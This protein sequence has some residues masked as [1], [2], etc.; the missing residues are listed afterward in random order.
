M[1]KISILGTNGFL[2]N[3]IA[4]YFKDSGYILEMYGRKEP[5]SVTYDSFYKLDLVNDTVNYNKLIQSDVI[6]YTIGAGIQSNLKESPDLI[7]MLNVTKPVEVCN[8]LKARDYEGIFVTFGSV[9]EIGETREKKLFIEDEIL[10]SNAKAS[11]DYTISKRMLSRFIQ[12]YTHKYIHW[13]FIIPTIYGPGENPK[14][15][16]PYTINAIRKNDD[17]HFTSG[18]QVRQYLFVE[19]VPKVIELS[20]ENKLPNGI[21]NIEGPDIISVKELVML[22]HKLMGVSVPRGCFGSEYR[23][24]T[25]MKYLALDGTKLQSYIKFKTKIDLDKALSKY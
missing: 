14:R 13:H 16:I 9:F 23:A 10:S 6:I 25:G 21:Y 7:Y 8:E 17:L 22:I 11:N 1:M 3:S 12:S 18:D 5:E 20:I 24:D 19:D 4:K 2:S 15:L